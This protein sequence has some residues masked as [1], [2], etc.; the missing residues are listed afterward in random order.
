MNRNEAH[1]VIDSERVY[2]DKMAG[3]YTLPL[4]G[5]LLLLESYAQQARDVYMR[6]FGDPSE[7]ATCE[8]IR[9]IAAIAQR[10]IENHGAPPRAA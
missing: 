7:L 6:T 4:E 8:M 3:T 1:A 9:K 10:C 2:Q 5:E